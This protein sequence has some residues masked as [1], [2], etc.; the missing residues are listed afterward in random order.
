MYND[1][2]EL[3]YDLGYGLI[4]TPSAIYVYSDQYIRAI[5]VITRIPNVYWRI[6]QDITTFSYVAEDCDPFVLIELK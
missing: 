4:V 1:L 2:I 5:H 6:I 3:L